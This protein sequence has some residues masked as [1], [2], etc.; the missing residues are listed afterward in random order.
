MHGGSGVSDRRCNIQP[1]GRPIKMGRR[2]NSNTA[3]IDHAIGSTSPVTGSSAKLRRDGTGFGL[4]ALPA[5]A[6]KIHSFDLIVGCQTRGGPSSSQYIPRLSHM[7]LCNGRAR[8]GFEA[9]RRG[10]SWASGGI[11]FFLP[12]FRLRFSFLFLGMVLTVRDVH[13]TPKPNSVRPTSPAW[14]P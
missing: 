4:L 11:R 14:M 13:S 5:S 8:G 12:C 2:G 6:W 1:S 3:C 9:A 10:P 7:V